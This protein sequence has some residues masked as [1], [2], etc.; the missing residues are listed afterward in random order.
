MPTTMLEE[1]KIEIRD[2]P[3]ET[4]KLILSAAS[5]WECSPDEAARRLLNQLADPKAA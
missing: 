4:A 3:E 5:A 2:L 1:L